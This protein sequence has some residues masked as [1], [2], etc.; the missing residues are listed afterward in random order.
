MSD[1]GL[2]VSRDDCSPGRQRSQRELKIY[3]YVCFEKEL[4]K[5]VFIETLAPESGPLNFAV[6]CLNLGQVIYGLLFSHLNNGAA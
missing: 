6:L 1:P 5:A 4:I 3:T 2:A